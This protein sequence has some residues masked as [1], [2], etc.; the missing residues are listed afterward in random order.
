MPFLKRRF[1]V[2][3]VI[4][5]ISIVNIIIIVSIVIMLRRFI[6]IVISTIMASEMHVAPQSQTATECH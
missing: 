5:I 4:I 3:N 2:I 6:V 1:I